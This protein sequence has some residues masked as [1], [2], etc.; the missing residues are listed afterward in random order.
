MAV[1]DMNEEQ[2]IRQM[3]AAESLPSRMTIVLGKVPHGC[4]GAYSP[5]TETMSLKRGADRFAVC[6]EGAHAEHYHRCG[7]GPSNWPTD[8]A[9]LGGLLLAGEA[10]VGLWLSRLPGFLARERRDLSRIGGGRLPKTIGAWARLYPTK[11][12]VLGGG[13]RNNFLSMASVAV[14]I[15]MLPAI[16]A[17]RA[18]ADVVLT[19]DIDLPV[20]GEGNR[21][22]SLARSARSLADNPSDLIDLTKVASLGRELIDL[23]DK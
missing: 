8:E 9:T 12:E 23:R 10:Y 5:D 7:I 3:L 2:R 6:H 22:L 15:R 20:G 16:V 4:N 21:L 14:L 17:E 19:S 13:F 11:Q 18:L 1:V